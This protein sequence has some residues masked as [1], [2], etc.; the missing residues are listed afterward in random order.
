[1]FDTE[2]LKDKGAFI[3]GATG[4]IGKAIA[5]DLAKSGCNLF[6]T[7][8]DNSSL[9]V[10][11]KELSIYN[12]NIAYSAANL[13]DKTEIYTVIDDAKNSLDSIDILV[14][15]AGIFPNMSLLEIQDQDYENVM[16]VNFR[17]PFIFIREFSKDMVKNEW[18]R[19]VNIGSS[20]SYFGYAETSLYCASKHALLGLSRSIHDELKQYNVRTF[21][22]SPSSTQSRMGLTTKNQDYSTFIDPSDISKYVVFVISHNSNIVSEEIFLKRMIIQ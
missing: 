19:I 21:C 15:S 8:T 14:N 9:E 10:L 18:G 7:S 4:A 5:T 1:M 17:A 20:S 22:I 16:A 11:A 2:I 3:S 6:L 13:V 12:V